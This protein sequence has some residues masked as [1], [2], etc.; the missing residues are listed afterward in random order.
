V[1]VELET[2]AD[3]QILAPRLAQKGY[4][5]INIAAILGEN[6]LGMLQNNLPEVV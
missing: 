4:T 6:W 1:P 2:I 3:L 5:E